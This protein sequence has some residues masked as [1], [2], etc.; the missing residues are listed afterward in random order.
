MKK[1]MVLEGGFSNE[2][3]TSLES[4]E[5]IKKALSNNKIYDVYGVDLKYINFEEDFLTNRPDVVFIALQGKYGEDGRIQGMLDILKI[6]YTHSGILA[7]AISMNK[8]LSKIVVRNFSE[9]STPECVIIHKGDNKERLFKIFDKKEIDTKFLIKP[10]DEGQSIGIKLLNNIRE[11]NFDKYEWGNRDTVMV[12]EYI[13]GR[14]FSVTVLENTIL[15][16]VEI[17]S[18]NIFFDTEAKDNYNM[19]EYKFDNVL[20]KEKHNELKHIAKKIHMAL[21]CKYIS[22]SDFILN[23]KDNKFY[24]LETNTHPGLTY[25]HSLTPMSLENLGYNLFDLC[26]YLIENAQ[27]EGMKKLEYFKFK[28]LTSKDINQIIKKHEKDRSKR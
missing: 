8:Y 7:S 20:S 6:P 25:P 10:I 13:A 4:G 15:D 24:Y 3:Y 23:N 26:V 9:I 11:F 27:Y 14:E 2:R 16:A 22:R 5:S 1:I 12:E 21:G 28:H 18:K 19:T 17:I